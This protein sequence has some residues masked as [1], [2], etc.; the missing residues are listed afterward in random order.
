MFLLYFAIISVTTVIIAS[1]D[2]KD[3]LADN[4]E[5]Q[6]S[7]NYTV[8]YLFSACIVTMGFLIMY[9][10]HL[11]CTIHNRQ[12]YY[13]YYQLQGFTYQRIFV[14]LLALIILTS[15]IPILGIFFSSI[16]LQLLLIKHYETVL[17]LEQTQRTNILDISEY[18]EI[19]GD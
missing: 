13:Q 4:F 15:F 16:F 2:Q 10:I 7:N 14:T 12:L 11:F 5:R 18:E 19:G 17:R 1:I 3:Q 8:Y 9:L 6:I